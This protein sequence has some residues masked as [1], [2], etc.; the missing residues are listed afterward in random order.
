[1]ATSNSYNFA[2]IDVDTVIRDAFE[3]CEIPNNKISALKYTAALNSFNFMFSEWLNYGFNL[4][5]VQQGIVPLYQGQNRYELP[6]IVLSLI[7]E[8]NLATADQILGGIATSS[9]G[10]NASAPFTSSPSSSVSCQQT[11]PN[12]N[13][14]YLYPAAE[15]IVYVGVMSAVT[16]DYEITFECSYLTSPSE[17]D[18]I[19]VLQT[20]SLT[21]Y[22]GQA[23]FFVLPYTKSAVNWR[24]R[25]T[26]GA[27]LNVSQIY[28]GIP[29]EIQPMEPVGRDLFFRFN[30]NNQQGAS[31][32]Y[33]FD[34][35]MTPVLN[36]YPF[37][38]TQYQF[39]TF[40]YTNII[41]DINSSFDSLPTVSRFI[42]A[43]T[44]GLAA[45]LAE[46]YV[47]DPNLYS[48][49]LAS[50]DLAY[51]KAGGEDTERVRTQIALGQYQ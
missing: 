14:S 34:R 26:G 47:T 9:A 10:G 44:A 4:F 36:V 37:S 16:Q 39:C 1:M 17:D 40:N 49:I 3:R 29:N 45:K 24:I 7:L 15:P 28:F 22:F 33:W 48:Q 50:A 27:I 23:N 32:Q 46:K 12:G 5:T 31:T 41:Q 21:Y 6:G 18:W 13:I 20:P 35:G 11:S 2:N 30:V 51:K 25:E 43:G 8:S 38:S 42:N 19:T